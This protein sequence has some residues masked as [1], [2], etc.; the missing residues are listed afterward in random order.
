MGILVISV[1]FL[2]L[3]I[4]IVLNIINIYYVCFKSDNDL[5]IN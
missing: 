1:E 4:K 3:L 5:F 2:N